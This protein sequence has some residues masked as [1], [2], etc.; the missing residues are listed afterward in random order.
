[1]ID[2]LL[3]SRIQFGFT[4]GFHILF[5]ALNLGLALFLC[6]MEGLWL[7][8]KDPAYLQISKFWG[9]IFALTFGMGVVS[10]IVLAYELGTN[11][12]PFIKAAGG[13]LGPLFGYEVLSAFFLE[14]GF[15]GIMLFGWDRVSPRLHYAATLLVMLG[16]TISAFWIMSAN[17]WM[18]APAGF[19]LVNGRYV[20][21]DWWQVVFNPT[22][23]PRFIH[24]LFASYVT[25]CFVVAGVAAWH[26]LRQ[27]HLDIS[28]RCFNFALTAALILTPL[29]II[30][31][32]IVG[33]EVGHRQPMKLAAIE[34]LWETTKGAPFLLFAL[35]DKQTETNR[36]E[37]RIPYLASLLNTHDPYGELVGLKSVPATERPVISPVFFGFRIMIAIGFLLFGVTV[38][39]AILRWRKRLYDQKRFLQLC[40]ALS[41]IGFV[42]TIAGWMVAESGRQPWTI[43]GL[44]RTAEAGSNV[45]AG[46]VMT[47]LSVFII[48]YGIVFSFYLYYLFIVIRKGPPAITA[49]PELETGDIAQ[50]FHYMGAESHD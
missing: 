30:I 39:A 27:Q 36:Y 10:G 42:A 50:P 29:Q 15:L 23:I 48:V 14:A 1:M 13:V 46:Q 16:T 9:K 17:S 34:G 38:Y 47:S 41:P 19:E 6:I 5:P 22:F 32:D 8:T 49:K 21:T 24:M 28:K 11:F 45:P 33:L 2:T 43:Y 37:M 18:Q 26:L 4:I 35:P 44:M 31:G 40:V 3:L 12:G 20:V 25:T 7:K